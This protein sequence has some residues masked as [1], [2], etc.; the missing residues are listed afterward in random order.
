MRDSYVGL[1]VDRAL[2]AIACESRPGR[3]TACS[4]RRRGDR[5]HAAQ[6]GTNSLNGGSRAFAMKIFVSYSFRA[7]NRWVDEY[8]VPL[9]ECFGHQVVTGRMLDAGPLDEEV[10][11]RI[12]Q[13]RRVLCFVT[14]AEPRYDQN[15]AL[16][17]YMPPDWVRDELMMARGA[18]RDAI[19]FR[20]SGVTYG[21]AAPFRAFWDFDREQL[22]KLL[23]DLALRLAEWP[24]GRLQLRLA[25]PDEFRVEIAQAANASTLRA[26]CAAIDEEGAV[27]SAE[28]LL[29]YIRD[30]QL[31]VPFW[32]KPDPDLSI[33]IE[34]TVG[35]RR[36]ACRGLSPAVRE[37][38]LSVV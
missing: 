35:A 10:R 29:V 15:G 30:G 21:G 26:R 16:V 20:E 25:V 33:E 4:G 17:R 23:V 7:E 34:I 3:A 37:A 22:P 11:R 5:I 36:L 14:R 6:H 2:L 24:V 13:C 9:I 12:S 18:N 8:V 19:E 32:I 27:R 1:R 28:D 38:R 31:V